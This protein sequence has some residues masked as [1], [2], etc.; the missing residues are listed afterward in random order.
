MFC[1]NIYFLRFQR[2]SNLHTF[3]IGDLPIIDFS[4]YGNNPFHQLCIKLQ[5]K[6]KYFNTFKPLGILKPTLQKRGER[7]R[8]EHVRNKYMD[9]SKTITGKRA[10]VYSGLGV[11]RIGNPQFIFVKG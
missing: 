6:F 4:L 5:R 2:I 8:G 9:E 10:S 11:E 1:L 7:E 3:V